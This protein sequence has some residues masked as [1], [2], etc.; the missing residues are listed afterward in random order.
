MRLGQQ[1]VSFGS[2]HL[3][4]LLFLTWSRYVDLSDSQM[5]SRGLE[6]YITLHY[7]DVQLFLSYILHEVCRSTDYE[8]QKSY[9]MFGR[10]NEKK[11]PHWQILLDELHEVR[12]F[13]VLFPLRFI[14]FANAIFRN[15]VFI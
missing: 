8:V 2:W 15:I 10:F 14:Q 4:L 13:Q 1:C 6:I 3:C 7:S 5:S 12:N 11:P 9:D